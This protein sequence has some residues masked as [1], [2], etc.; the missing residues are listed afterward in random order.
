MYIDQSLYP[1]L[2]Q[3]PESL[4]SPEGKADYLHRVCTAWDFGIHP[5]PETFELLGRWRDV[6]DRFPVATSPAY[7]AL[8]CWFGWPEV[9][10]PAGIRPP[11][12][13]WLHLDRQEGRPPDPC[14]NMI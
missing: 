5:E 2:D 4:D 1:D 13:R 3:P 11:T 9:P 7:H 10:W 14:E 12:P 6:F 8:R